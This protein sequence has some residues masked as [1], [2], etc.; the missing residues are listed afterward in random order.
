[1]PIRDRLLAGTV[2]L[3]WGLNF[4]ATDFGLRQFPPLLMIVLRF[5]VLAVPTVLFVPRPRV[6]WRWLIGYGLGFGTAQYAFLYIAMR[7]GMPAGLASVVLQSSAPFTVLIAAAFLR[8]R[9]SRTQVAGIVIA[10]AGLAALVCYRAQVAAA[11]PVLLTVCGGLGWAVGNVCNRQARP[12]SPLRLTLWMSV[13]PPVPMLLLSLLVEGPAAAR[14]ALSGINS[15]TGWTALAALGYIVLPATVLGAGIWTNLLRRHPAAVV[16]PFSLLIP[17][18]GI[19][20]AWLVLHQRPA[21]FELCASAVVI[22][23]VLLGSRG[24]RIPTIRPPELAP[25]TPAVQGTTPRARR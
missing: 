16:A 4:L 9:L 19:A 17:V 21:V 6:R 3:L 11:V 18:I 22:L 23:G 20:A 8:E 2:A 15:P 1:M 13:V 12:D 25:P 5:A 24:N 14:H 7:D 10:V